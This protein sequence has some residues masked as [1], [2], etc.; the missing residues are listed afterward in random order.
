MSRSE[1][2]E[3][4]DRT[5]M[6]R[7]RPEPRFRGLVAGLTGVIDGRGGAAALSVGRPAERTGTS[8]HGSRSPEDKP[9]R[10]GPQPEMRQ[11]RP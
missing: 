8:S 3:G 6:R 4:G 9:C 5:V 1:C 10:A 2:D 7:P 11:Q